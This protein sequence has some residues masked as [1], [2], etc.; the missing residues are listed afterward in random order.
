[1]ALFLKHFRQVSGLT[2]LS[3]LAGFARDA[4]LAHFL[5]AGQ[6]MS[7]YAT[8]FALP[9]A[10][11]NLFG[12]GA[13]SAAF[14]P[15]FTQYVES[16]DRKA[17][18]R[19]MSLVIVLLV[20]ALAALALVVVGVLAL[21]RH[22]SRESPQYH[23]LFGL[24]A[25]MFP[26]VIL[27][28]LVALLQAALNACRHFV[29]PALAP[30]VLNLFI[31]AG[32]VAGG[33]WMTEDAVGRAYL[34][35]ASILV[36]GVVEVAIQAPALVRAGL[37]F[38]PAWDLSH[39]ALRRVLALI[40]PMALAVGVI[41]INANMDKLVAYVLMQP[42][43]GAET[44]RLGALEAAYP[45]KTGAPA[46]L[47]YAQRLYWLPLGIFGIALS[48][49][50]FPE[51]SR[52]ALRQDLA[53]LARGA[54]HAMR[55]ALFVGVPAGAG[56]ILIS[57]PFI[58]LFLHHGRFADPAAASDAVQRTIWAAT[59]YATGIWAFSANH[60]LVRA[61]Y[62]RQDV[63]TPL[64]IAALSAGV[65][66]VLDL[67]LVWPLAEQGL[68]LATVAAAMV[69]LGG[70]VGLVNRRFAHLAWGEIARSA[71]R[72]LL[73][74][75]L[76]GA[77]V[78]GALLWAVPLLGWTGRPLYAVQCFGGVAVGA[79]VFLLVA[80]LLGMT[81]LGDLLTRAAPDLDPAPPL[82]PD[83]PAE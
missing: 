57:E 17:A 13:L 48:T 47:Y 77:A 51:F 37:A 60:V 1:V 12:E 68:A 65:N 75:A 29:L 9:N 63:R 26:F 45:M 4:V 71:A 73:A 61:F 27:V 64:R 42:E 7:A 54:S 66:L 81:E 33:L 32:A 39:P 56:I 52:F 76:M 11:R 24:A 3:R 58:R 55:L 15:V 36:A 23:L 20:T 62:A 31:I 49:V 72:T 16:G 5:G 53:G 35:A 69:Q 46:V 10:L 19:F 25:V 80:R 14:I 59:V 67:V 78:W 82:D 28:C 2:I 22:L 50:L 70:L 18:S 41:E 79:G 44:F 30:I 8:A 38:R 83:P 74:T 6:V 21:L 40:V 34:I 43:G